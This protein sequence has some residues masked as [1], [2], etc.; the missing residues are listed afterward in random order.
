MIG[1]CLR[2]HYVST[3]YGQAQR[4]R[5]QKALLG[6]ATTPRRSKKTRHFDYVAFGLHQKIDLGR[7]DMGLRPYGIFRLPGKRLARSTWPENQYLGAANRSNPG[8]WECRKTSAVFVP[9]QP[10]GRGNNPEYFSGN[11]GKSACQRRK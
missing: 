3:G 11:L 8:P 10:L 1:H 7:N 2:V 5:F 9:K 6:G 4:S